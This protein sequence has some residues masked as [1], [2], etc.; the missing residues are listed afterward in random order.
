MIEHLIQFNIRAWD[1]KIK[2]KI[3][4]EFR[5]EESELRQGDLPKL[6]IHFDFDP[7]DIPSTL[8]VTQDLTKQKPGFTL[9]A[10]IKID[11]SES[12][13]DLDLH[14][15]YTQGVIGEYK[16]SGTARQ[17]EYGTE[18][19]ELQPVMFSL[20]TPE[21][22]IESCKASALK[23]S[24]GHEI[25][26]LVGLISPAPQK[27]RGIVF[28]RLISSDYLVHNRYELEPKRI[29][30]EGEKELTW[31]I[32]IPIDETKSGMFK[33]LIEFKSKDTFAK[34]EFESIF[35]VRQ[36][37]RV[38]V[39]ALQSSKGIVSIGDEIEFSAELENVGLEKINI[40]T[41]L[42]I[43]KAGPSSNKN[44]SAKSQGKSQQVH[45]WT[46]EPKIVTIEPDSSFTPDWSWKVTEKATNGKYSLGLHWK[47]LDTGETFVYS[48]ETFEIRK[49]HE[50]K[51]LNAITEMETFDPGDEAIIKI[52]ITDSGTR[53]GEQLDLQWKILDIF[54]HEQFTQISNLVTNAEPFEVVLKWQVPTTLEGGRY[55][56]VLRILRNED[57][58]LLRK[59][60]KL[61]KVEL[62]VR[63]DL[64]LVLPSVSDLDIA[65]PIDMKPYLIE[66]E[67]VIEHTK[68]SGMDVY[69]LNSNTN[70]FMLNNQLIRYSKGSLSNKQTLV[71]FIDNL[72]SY[73]LVKE[74]E[75]INS[76]DEDI[77]FWW[78]IGYCL[79]NLVLM[80]SN[81]KKG[82][83]VQ[84]IRIDSKRKLSLRSWN[85]VAKSI[86]KD[87]KGK[88]PIKIKDSVK[89]KIKLD[90][91][92]NDNLLK[93]KSV[94]K[95]SEFNFIRSLLSYLMAQEQKFH[96]E[97]KNQ[98]GEVKFDGDKNIAHLEKLTQI[99]INST[100]LKKFT[101]SKIMQKKFNKTIVKMF[102]QIIN[103]NIPRETNKIKSEGI[104]SGYYFLMLYLVYE[105][106]SILT[107]WKHNKTVKPAKYC[108]LILFELSYYLI[109]VHFSRSQAK[110]SPLHNLRDPDW[111]G[112]EL[113]R[114]INEGKKISEKYWHYH[115]LWQNRYINYFKN[116]VKRSSLAFMHEHVTITT[117][118]VILRGKRNEQASAKLILGNNGSRPVVV[119]PYLGLPT[120]HW[121]LVL[122]EAI[123]ENNIYKLKRIKINPKQTKEIPMTISFPASLSFS[124]YTGVLKL[125]PKMIKLLPE[126]N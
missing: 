45:S 38:K 36:A 22:E 33:A 101:T 110:Y 119:N 105:I 79:I 95:S 126:F 64:H 41:Y 62:P 91:I 44:T 7:E 29:S 85:A 73:L 48:E 116:I 5:L 104:N 2:S 20:K 19:V 47:D 8:E 125:N 52:V 117:N 120:N 123:Y 37:K 3:Q 68:F 14:L 13:L 51:I 18:L 92:F 83:G 9:Q 90:Q 69:K 118:P 80:D 61:V 17:A 114:D 42:A 57:E 30:I 24:K 88:D 63:L 16:I 25:D 74:C 11:I 53:A 124:S 50:L 4:A 121:N 21:V 46:L 99:L 84:D 96:H 12:Q 70:I 39:K 86:L 35:E 71:E 6:Q 102:N 89:A 26:I 78:K 100:K 77:D 10:P 107:Q 76:L 32:K 98:G 23:I 111:L 59:L 115:K 93:N 65:V 94:T 82:K 87:A 109:L 55:D 112:A 31:H 54:N 72:F 27:L 97:M 60:S 103:T 106:T 15:D 113:G 108:K 1:C 66:N 67:N 58:L 40:E 28:G 49:F 43:S 81:I 56:L 34:K 75:F 122:P